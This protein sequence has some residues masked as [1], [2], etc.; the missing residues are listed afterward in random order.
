MP[1]GVSVRAA[2]P[3]VDWSFPSRVSVAASV[4]VVV[5][6][7]GL[8]D[9]FAAP[10]VGLYPSAVVLVVGILALVAGSVA[11]VDPTVARFSSSCR[12]DLASALERAASVDRFDVSVQEHHLCVAPTVVPV[13]EADTVAPA[14]WR[15]S[16]PPDDGWYPSL[17]AAD[18]SSLGN[19]FQSERQRPDRRQSRRLPHPLNP[20][21]HHRWSLQPLKVYNCCFQDLLS[22]LDRLGCHP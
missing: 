21:P 14:G 12:S 11:F 20:M 10:Y 3:A 5:E 19:G 9:L 17:I 16:L 13:A 4:Y 18:P 22:C 7:V 2:N 6:R 1:L 15:C 8:G